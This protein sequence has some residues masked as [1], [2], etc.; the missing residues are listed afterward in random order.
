M[1]RPFTISPLLTN[2]QQFWI[3][4][5]SQQISVLILSLLFP[6]LILPINLSLSLYLCTGYRVPPSENWVTRWI[7]WAHMSWKSI[8]GSV[9]L[10]WYRVIQRKT[11]TNKQLWWV[12]IFS[13]I[14]VRS[15]T[16]TVR[17]NNLL[18]RKQ[19]KTIRFSQFTIKCNKIHTLLMLIQWL[20]PCVIKLLI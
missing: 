1:A 15:G 10:L 17:L 6:W 2:F 7:C 20:S 16:H 13:D 14:Y 3:P 19:D 12:N 4:S 9:D 18:W 5:S 8:F 11:W